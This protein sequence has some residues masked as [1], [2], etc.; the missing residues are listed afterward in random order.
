MLL[1]DHMKQHDLIEY[2]LPL[3]AQQACQPPRSRKEASS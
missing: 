3:G 1:A 2:V